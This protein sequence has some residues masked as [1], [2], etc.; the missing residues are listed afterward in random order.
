MRILAHRVSCLPNGQPCLPSSF[1]PTQ[2]QI[3]STFQVCGPSRFGGNM[4][5]FLVKAS[6]HDLTSVVVVDLGSDVWYNPHHYK[7]AG[8]GACLGRFTLFQKRGHE[9]GP[10][11]PKPM[12]VFICM[13]YFD[14]QEPSWDQ[15]HNPRMSEQKDKKNLDP[16][17]CAEITLPLSFLLC[18]I[19]NITIEDTFSCI[20][21]Y[22]QPKHPKQCGFRDTTGKMVAEKIF[23][24][25]KEGK[26]KISSQAVQVGRGSWS[27][28]STWEDNESERGGGG[29]KSLSSGARNTSP[30]SAGWN[31]L[32]VAAEVLQGKQAGFSILS[33]RQWYIG[34]HVTVP[35]WKQIVCFQFVKVLVQAIST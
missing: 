13:C 8:V 10:S 3:L 28:Y 9:Q 11:V 17:G 19:V 32:K 35:C 27:I 29:L 16:Q 24:R 4:I 2:N 22:L 31:S 23:L 15:V 21:H 30:W 1:W 25:N 14:L 26:R 18:P 7:S 20:F 6:H 34:A 33:R 5:F 12:D